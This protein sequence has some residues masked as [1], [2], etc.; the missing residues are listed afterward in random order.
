ME[1]VRKLLQLLELP[2]PLSDESK[3][4]ALQAIEVLSRGNPADQHT[5][6]DLLDALQ[7][8]MSKCVG[9]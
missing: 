6:R 5:A 1:L 2:Q 7:L 8:E 4:V 9:Q 3:L